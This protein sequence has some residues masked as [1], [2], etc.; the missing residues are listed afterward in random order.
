MASLIMWAVPETTSVI[1]NGASIMAFLA[2]SRVV[3]P[4]APATIYCFHFQTV[5]LYSEL[6]KKYSLGCL[7][8]CFCLLRF[9]FFIGMFL[10]ESL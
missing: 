7:R 10:V 1:L 2:L 9:L 3:L 6:L 4:L 8:V 5:R